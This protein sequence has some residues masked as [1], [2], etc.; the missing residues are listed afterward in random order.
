MTPHAVSKPCLCCGSALKGRTDKKFC[1]DFCRNSYNNQLKSHV[2]N[3]VRNINNALKKNRRI[4]QELLPPGRQTIKTTRERLIH[5]GFKF[6]YCTHI[7][8][9][10]EGH[11]YVFCYEYGF[12]PLD[13]NWL[14]VVKKDDTPG[15]SHVK[16]PVISR[17]ERVKY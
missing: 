8:I 7:H 13:N 5:R 11:Q 17:G 10:K 9:T 15:N 16:A 4:L 1:D 2:N 3:Y 12:L 6:K 14:L